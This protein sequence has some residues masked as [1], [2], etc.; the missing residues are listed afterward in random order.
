MLHLSNAALSKDAKKDNG[1]SFVTISMGKEIKNLSIAV[2]SPE[3]QEMQ[4]LDLYLN[5]SQD[6]TISCQ[7]KNEVHLS[8]YFEPNSSMDDQMFPE[9]VDLG[10]EEDE[11]ELSEDELEDL[12]ADAVKE[13]KKAATNGKKAAEGV[14]GFKKGG[15]LD[16]SLKAAKK[17]AIK[18]TLPQGDDSSSDGED[19]EEYGDEDLDLEDESGEDMGEIDLEAEEGEDEELDSDE[20]V[21]SDDSEEDAVIKK[22]QEKKKQQ[23]SSSAK[24][25]ASKDSSD[26]DS[27]DE[28]ED[29]DDSD[30]E[31]E[32]LAT[33]LKKQKAKSHQAASG[34]SP[35]KAQKTQDKQHVPAAQK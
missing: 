4:R 8:G 28:K 16:K 32:D 23:T 35:S 18:N 13:S 6:I 2:L 3:R 33:L 12:K 26:D 20:L 14:E 29:E 24:V 11:D 25:A 1:K 31:E 17:N 10:E 5:I 15:D 22:L 30:E 19:G 7:G 34:G 21:G 9:G 27:S